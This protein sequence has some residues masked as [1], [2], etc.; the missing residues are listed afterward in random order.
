MEK[1]KDF[2][3]KDSLKELDKGQNMQ[4][5]GFLD[6]T[7]KKWSVGVSGGAS[8]FHGDADKV[9]PSWNVGPYVKYSISQN[10]WF[11]R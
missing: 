10:F 7:A 5:S 6:R 1:K 3:W 11:K 8:F 4:A 9:I 2:I